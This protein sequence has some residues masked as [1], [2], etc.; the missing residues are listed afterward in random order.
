M[1][2]EAAAF[3]GA[4]PGSEYLTQWFESTSKAGHAASVY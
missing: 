2:R 1:E 4:E 3:P